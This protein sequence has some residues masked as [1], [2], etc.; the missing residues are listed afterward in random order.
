MSSR[1]L[2]DTPPSRPGK[3]SR[4]RR[5]G[6]RWSVK[7]ERLIQWLAEPSGSRSPETLGAL[8]EALNLRPAT[9][10]RWKRDPVLIR[11]VYHAA[12][13][14]L[15]QRIG[16]ILDTIGTKAMAGDYRFVKLALD[17]TA[18]YREEGQEVVYDRDAYLWTLGRVAVE[19]EELLEEI[20]QKI[21]EENGK[22]GMDQGKVLQGRLWQE[23]G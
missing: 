18:A 6:K 8:A 19:E 3:N 1:R 2:V 22:R 7:Q 23:D 10:A 20:K 15:N 17:L 4:P 11:E 21:R 14:R 9:L 12:E 13:W 5:T 16:E